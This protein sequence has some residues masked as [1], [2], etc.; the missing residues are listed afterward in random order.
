MRSAL[1]VVE[2]W[3]KEGVWEGIMMRR[4]TRVIAAFILNLFPGLGFYFS[5][6]V[7]SLKWLRLLGSGLIAAF[8]F[9]IP[10][11]VVILHPY[12]LIN[13]RFTASEL[14]LPSAVALVS[15]VAGA[16][17]EQKLSK[18]AQQRAINKRKLRPWLSGHNRASLELRSPN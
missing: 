5:G 12:P 7:H 11:T 4:K 3:W 2:K 16:S 6:S 13:Y 17:V 10:I 8:L 18:A 14:I 9:I 1:N 15:G